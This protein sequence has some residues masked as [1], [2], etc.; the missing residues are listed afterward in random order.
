MRKQLASLLALAVVGGLSGCVQGGGDPPP[1]PPLARDQS[2]PALAL[3]EHVLTGYF[4]GAGANAPTTCV[5]LDPGPLG[6][7]RE[8]ALILRFVRLAPAERCRTQGAGVVDAITGGPA[9]LVQVYRF[10]CHDSAHCTGWASVPGAPAMAYAM[11]YEDGAWHFVG[12]PRI[13]A[14]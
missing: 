4:A 10:A 14:E 6:K 11:S 9:R 3:F 1:L 7:D 5:S 8:E 2:Q 12:D 13:I